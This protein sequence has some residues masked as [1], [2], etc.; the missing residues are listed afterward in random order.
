M[1]D[2]LLYFV[3]CGMFWSYVI[4]ERERYFTFWKALDN[5]IIHVTFNHNKISI[6]EPVTR[7]EKNDL[8]FHTVGNSFTG[9]AVDLLTKWNEICKIIKSNKIEYNFKIV[10]V[11]N[12]Y[13]ILLYLYVIYILK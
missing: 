3:C 13:F 12:I 7:K 5:Y 11:N 8:I 2:K 9:T 6:F 4:V 10:F 1:L